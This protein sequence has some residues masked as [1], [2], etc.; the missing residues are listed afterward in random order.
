MYALKENS[1]AAFT[2]TDKII[3]LTIIGETSDL[4]GSTLPHVTCIHH[5]TNTLVPLFLVK[6]NRRYPLVWYHK[7]SSIDEVDERPASPPII[8]RQRPTSHLKSLFCQQLSSSV[9]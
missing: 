3:L 5:E 1:Q 9:P 6:A 2:M 8:T 4:T 7:P